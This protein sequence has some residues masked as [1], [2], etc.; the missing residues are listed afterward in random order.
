MDPKLLGVMINVSFPAPE[1]LGNDRK[2]LNWRELIRSRQN[3]VMIS[4]SS[5]SRAAWLPSRSRQVIKEI[6]CFP[7]QHANTSRAQ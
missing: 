6:V 2:Q 7:G 1:Q 4:D 3:K 5:D